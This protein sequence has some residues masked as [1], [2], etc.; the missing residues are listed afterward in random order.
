MIKQEGRRCPVI[1]AETTTARGGGIG[2]GT[3]LTSQGRGVKAKR[4]PKTPN[5]VR[6][7]RRNRSGGAK[8][9]KQKNHG[10]HKGF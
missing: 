6:R 4:R 5:I 7:N 2:P 3:G 10:A 9:K 8:H 1:A